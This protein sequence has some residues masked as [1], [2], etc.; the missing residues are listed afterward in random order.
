MKEEQEPDTPIVNAEQDFFRID[1]LRTKKGIH[2]I[3]N[4][5]HEKNK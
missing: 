3:K 1:I 4:L 2:P 5:Y